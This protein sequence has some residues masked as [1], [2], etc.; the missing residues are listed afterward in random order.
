[1]NL[2]VETLNSKIKKTLILGGARSGKS[3]YGEQIVENCG[4]G[5]YLATAL[6]PNLVKD[7]EM[8]TRIAEHKKRRSRIWKTIEE[9]L[10]I[11][12]VIRRESLEKL[13][14]LVDCL[15]LW[16]SNLMFE[17]LNLEKEIYDLVE[18]LEKAV[19]PVICVSNEVG[20]GIVPENRLARE[21]RDNAGLL[22]QE[23]AKVSKLVVLVT[24]GIP[25]IVKDE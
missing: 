11:A 25:M 21:F 23:I 19:G 1:M 15:T 13:P 5:I 22:N 7:V 8:A 10:D 16:L 2:M 14:I 4:K 6:A 18:S 20:L 12:E 9:P 24:A 3:R 17:N